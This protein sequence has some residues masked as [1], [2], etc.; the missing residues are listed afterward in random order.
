MLS[1]KASTSMLQ[2]TCTS[3]SASVLQT[4]LEAACELHIYI[5]YIHFELRINDYNSEIRKKVELL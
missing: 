2:G 1:S 3:I 4:G 5:Y